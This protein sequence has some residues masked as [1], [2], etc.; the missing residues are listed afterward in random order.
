MNVLRKFQSSFRIKYT[1][2]IYG[3]YG[4]RTTIRVIRFMLEADAKTLTSNKWTF[5]SKIVAIMLKQSIFS[6][7][8]DYI[9]T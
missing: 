2:Y 5:S 7:R 3:I 9:R 1:S 8:R 4:K 6:R